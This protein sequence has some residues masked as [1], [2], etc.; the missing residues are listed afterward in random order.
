M[1]PER[2][3]SFF[4]IKSTLVSQLRLRYILTHGFKG[5]V[6]LKIDSGR[7]FATFSCDCTP[8]PQS[9]KEKEQERIKVSSLYC[10]LHYAL[11]LY[12]FSVT[13]TLFDNTTHCYDYKLSLQNAAV[14]QNSTYCNYID[15]YQK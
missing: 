7:K 3:L 8:L 14:L 4:L 13:H 1:S 10:H 15:T 2:F 9:N 5:F 12:L 6:S 11:C